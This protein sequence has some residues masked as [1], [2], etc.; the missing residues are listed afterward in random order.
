MDV[1]LNGCA[2]TGTQANKAE[3]V[4]LCMP[5]IQLVA[6]GGLQV[7]AEMHMA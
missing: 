4:L 3:S 1:A 2:L 7:T 5:V 6:H